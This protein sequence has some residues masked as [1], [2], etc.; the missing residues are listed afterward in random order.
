MSRRFIVA[1]LALALGM[2]T[3]PPVAQAQSA[4]PP[5]PRTP[6]Q[7]F[8][9]LMEE[10][11]SFDSYFGGY[12]GAE[13]IPEDA[14]VLL[15]AADKTCTKPKATQEDTVALLDA[16]ARR[17]AGYITLDHF[18]DKQVPF[19]WN[20][21]DRF[22]LF[23]HYFSS[24]QSKLNATNRN[25]MQWV[26]G[27]TVKSERI[28]PK[29]YGNLRTIFD[30]LEARGI[31]WKFYVEDYNAAITFR[32]RQPNEALPR[33]IVK[34]PLLNLARF[35]DDP[36]LSKR[37]VDLKEYY[38]D[39]QN[40]TLPAVSYIVANGASEPTPKSLTLGQRHLKTVMQELMRSSAWP[41]SALLWTHDQSGGWYDHVEPPQVDE[42][43]LGLRVPAMLISPY[44]LAGKV[45]S[46]VLEHSS[47]LK[48]IEYNWDLAPLSTRDANANNFLGAF[49]FEAGP[50]AA[51]FLPWE[52][53]TLI[54]RTPREPVRL[55][56]FVFYGATLALA[57]VLMGMLLRSMLS[58]KPPPG[59]GKPFGPAAWKLRT[60]RNR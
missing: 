45:D 58:G 7:H 43:G 46:T 9:V 38:T 2:A 15:D 19:Y 59:G 39:L 4:Q 16:P 20:V 47:I 10:K 34:V 50:R 51:E 12:P 28:P 56:I 24:V 44:A 13:V 33:Q 21:A 52:R 22:V 40:G 37:I 49:N 29:G 8:I 42:F 18:T 26:A 30:R 41:A 27:V 32:S 35:I 14:C 1:G 48:F 55:W 31:S 23:D 3:L 57:I 54:S 17:Y 6:I 25:Q 36:A 60:Q 11:R 5:Q 53:A